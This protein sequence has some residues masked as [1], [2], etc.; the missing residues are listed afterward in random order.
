MVKIF[1]PF[2]NADVS[3]KNAEKVATSVFKFI[4]HSKRFEQDS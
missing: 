3:D 4:L 2:N 1:D